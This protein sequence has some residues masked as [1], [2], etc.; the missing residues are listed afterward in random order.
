MNRISQF[1]HDNK[2]LLSIPAL[3]IRSASSVLNAFVQLNLSMMSP[4]I[5]DLTKR[6]ITAGADDDNL[7]ISLQARKI[8][9][10]GKVPEEQ[11]QEHKIQEM[12]LIDEMRKKH[13]TNKVAE[14]PSITNPKLMH[15]TNMAL[16]QFHSR[17]VSHTENQTNFTI[18][19][20]SDLNSHISYVIQL[21]PEYEGAILCLMDQHGKFYPFD[22]TKEGKK[23][24][25]IC[26]EG[27]NAKPFLDHWYDTLQE[28]KSTP[29]RHVSF[30][31]DVDFFVGKDVDGRKKVIKV[32]LNNNDRGVK[33]KG[34]LWRRS[35]V[36]DDLSIQTQIGSEIFFPNKKP[37]KANK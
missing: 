5:N 7:Q 14:T 34:G 13:E 29:T 27:E 35:N 17:L 12:L 26:L 33:T 3:I 9:E 2:Y 24:Y 10:E 16:G 37:S 8:L 11:V 6:T 18:L 21:F 32:P 20:R 23:I 31:E 4:L 36:G 22:I 28:P 19:H 30:Q 1:Y 25:E 15:Y